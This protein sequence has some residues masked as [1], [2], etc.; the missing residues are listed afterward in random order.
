[1]PR[2]L[3]PKLRERYRQLVQLHF[4]THNP[5]FWVTNQTDVTNWVA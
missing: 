2:Q 4:M 1:M 5:A 3:I